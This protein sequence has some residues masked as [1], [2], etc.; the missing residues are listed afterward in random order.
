[1]ELKKA[2]LICCCFSLAGLASWEIYW[3]SQGY[4]ADI[5]DDKYL[6]ADQRAKVEKADTNDV[7]LIGSSRILFDIQL[8]VWEKA[9][10]YKPIQLASPGSTP[11]PAFRDLVE[12]TDFSGTVIVGVTPGLFFS[13]T[14]PGARPW[15]RMQAKVDCFHNRT[16][17]QR[18][19]HRLSIPLQKTFVFL[20]KGEEDWSDDINLKGFLNRIY[21][22]QRTE[23][24]RMPPFYKFMETS[25][26]RNVR[27]K[28][29]VVED[30]AFANSIR[31]VWLAFTPKERKDDKEGT[32]KFFLEDAKKF[33]A[34]GGNLILLYCPSD[35]D[36]KQKENEN[37]PR[38]D[39]WDELVKQ[40]GA[41]AYHYEDYVEFQGLNV[42]EWSHL[43]PEDADYFTKELVNILLKDQA[44]PHRKNQ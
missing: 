19:N 41:K 9:A 2:F 7:I 23:K 4:I 36:I 13:T 44:I 25:I 33:M 27:M 18:L 24:P 14:F 22:G 34:R 12:N 20:S 39:Y 21:L 32:I 16:Y 37:L 17:A 10:G 29:R 6:W 30:T 43:A 11:L 5:E 38:A 15:K 40:S 1:M 28:N 31:R 42:P 8:P 35:G 3:R 26:D